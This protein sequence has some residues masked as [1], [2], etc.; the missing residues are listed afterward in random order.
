MNGMKDVAGPLLGWSIGAVQP[1]TR[2]HDLVQFPCE[3]C[4]KAVGR[5]TSTFLPNMLARVGAVLGREVTDDEHSTRKSAQ[6]KYESVT[7]RLWV[8]SGDE[9]YAVYAALGADD[10]VK[11]LL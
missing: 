6:G 3:F 2:I 7:L 9:V 8:R 4:F 11:F 10:A 1:P 5:S